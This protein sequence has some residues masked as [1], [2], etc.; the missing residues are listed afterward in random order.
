MPPTNTHLSIPKHLGCRTLS[1][2]IV[3][4]F[5]S[6]KCL[7]RHTCNVSDAACL[8]WNETCGEKGN[9]WLYHKDN[10]RTYLNITAA[11]MSDI[12]LPVMVPKSLLSQICM[13]RIWITLPPPCGYFLKVGSCSDGIQITCFYHRWRYI[14]SFIKTV[15]GFCPK[16]V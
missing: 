11:G 15:I 10:F 8:V 5:V 6:Q 14:I 7:H 12:T 13:H 3:K 4:L 2:R 9:C 1:H 16:P